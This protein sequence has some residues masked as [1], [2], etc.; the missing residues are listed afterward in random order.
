MISEI[1]KCLSDESK[2]N[3]FYLEASK[4]IEDKKLIINTLL[5]SKS[6]DQNLIKFFIKTI[7]DNEFTIDNLYFDFI[8]KLNKPLSLVLYSKEIEILKEKCKEEKI[9]LEESK[10]K[11]SV[12]YDNPFENKSTD[13]DPELSPILNAAKS[14]DAYTFNEL[15]IEG[16][17]V[18]ADFTEKTVEVYKYLKEKSLHTRS[19]NFKII[20]DLFERQIIGYLFDLLNKISQQEK[21]LGQKLTNFGFYSETFKF[22][23]EL[24]TT[25]LLDI[26]TLYSEYE[27]DIIKNLN[28]TNQSKLILQDWKSQHQKGDVLFAQ[29]TDNTW[30]LYLLGNSQKDFIQKD[31]D[32][33]SALRRGLSNILSELL[34]QKK[35]ELHKLLN[36]F[37]EGYTFPKIKPLILYAAELDN[38]SLVNFLLSMD[39]FNSDTISRG[40]HPKSQ[41]S[42]PLA[43]DV[44]SL[45]ELQGLVIQ[46]LKSFREI[47]ESMK[48]DYENLRITQ[49][50]KNPS[51]SS[52]EKAD[53]K[54]EKSYIEKLNEIKSFVSE[55]EKIL[56]KVTNKL[57]DN[58]SES[59]NKFS[60][61]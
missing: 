56:T 2:M 12:K 4:N 59:R 23:K 39:T 8:I 40:Y 54:A 20:Y 33:D 21:T 60:M 36:S 45:E 18:T 15:I 42:N 25:G 48:K 29:K 57:P 10:K 41:P 13:T 30:T 44:N 28:D 19:N 52:K 35:Y 58:K 3:K 26:N 32:P 50:N 6:S 11:L 22:Y 46:K 51:P 17:S 34:P 9:S 53:S 5:S 61:T 43:L 1:K 16:D 49:M 37:I 27:I 47:Q 55:Y 31:I 7:E 38:I 14:E 24:F